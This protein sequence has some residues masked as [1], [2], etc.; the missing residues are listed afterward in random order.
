MPAARSSGMNTSFRRRRRRCLASRL[1]S[2]SSR[3]PRS[4][5][6]AGRAAEDMS[7]V[8]RAGKGPRVRAT[9]GIVAAPGARQ[10][11]DTVGKDQYTRQA[12]TLPS[13]RH[14]GEGCGEVGVRGD[15]LRRGGRC[16][17]RRRRGT[18]PRTR[19]Q[20]ARRAGH[21]DNTGSPGRGRRRASR[22]DTRAAPPAR[23]RASAPDRTSRCSPAARPRRHP[24]GTG[25]WAACSSSP[26]CRSTAGPAAPPRA[27]A[28]QVRARELVRIRLGERDHRIAE[29][30]EIRPRV[31][32][33]D[34]V[35]RDRGRRRIVEERAG[36]RGTDARPPKIP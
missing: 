28:E 19:I 32:A 18:R 26:A 13:P 10:G 27:C 22:A 9:W 15:L 30:E 21:V 23:P 4:A 16:R 2:G 8:S 25:R 34:L 33:I 12:L 6:D 29:D 36:G 14:Q 11:D 7:I 31:A 20:S 35:T 17:R 1:R 24:C 5:S 3:L